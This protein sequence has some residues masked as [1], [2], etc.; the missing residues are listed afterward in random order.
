MAVLIVIESMIEVLPLLNSPYREILAFSIWIIGVAGFYVK[1]ES[2]INKRKERVKPLIIDEIND[3]IT[4]LIRQL[5]VEKPL[6]EQKR[7]DYQPFP[8]SGGFIQKIKP[9]PLPPLSEDFEIINQTSLKRLRDEH[10]GFL[11]LSR[12]GSKIDTRNKLVKELEDKLTEI[13]EMLRPEVEKTYPPLIK[14]YNETAEEKI[15][16]EPHYILSSVIENDRELEVI[17]IL[18]DFWKIHC[19]EIL[20]LRDIP[21]IKK[22]IEKVNILTDE[23]ESLTEE[24]LKYLQSLKINYIE[25]YV[26]ESEKIIIN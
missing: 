11:G 1:W 5:K 24:M 26:I 7:Y 23:L 15:T 6:I 25:E 10:I 22:E 13:S 2:W 4:P 8:H 16:L 14:K 17:N 9:F 19:K 20:I 21:E 12:F 18:K 3:V